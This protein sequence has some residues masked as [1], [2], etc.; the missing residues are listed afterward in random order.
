MRQRREGGCA[1]T[2]ELTLVD[3]HGREH[4]GCDL[5]QQLA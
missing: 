5:P 4:A 1:R 3:A 2:W